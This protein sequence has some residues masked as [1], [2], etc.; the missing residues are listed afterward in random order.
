MPIQDRRYFIQKHN[1]EQEGY[2]K[3]SDNARNASMNGY[4]NN[5]DLN[6]YAKLEQENNRNRRG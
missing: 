1:A 2:N 4:R 3:A 6:A 5:G